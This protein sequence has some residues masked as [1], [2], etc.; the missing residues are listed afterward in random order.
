MTVHFRRSCGLGRGIVPLPWMH[1]EST[2]PWI[3]TPCNAFFPARTPPYVHSHPTFVAQ[4]SERPRTLPQSWL[5]QL[6]TRQL[7]VFWSRRNTLTTTYVHTCIRSPIVMPVP[8]KIMHP[9]SC[10]TCTCSAGPYVDTSYS[11]TGEVGRCVSA[12]GKERGGM[13]VHA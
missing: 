1:L 7:E 5:L 12:S 8:S 10:G 4:V 13:C 6:H 9:Y 11:P 3:F 2:G